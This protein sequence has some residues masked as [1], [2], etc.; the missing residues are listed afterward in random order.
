MASS[1]WIKIDKINNVYGHVSTN[2]PTIIGELCNLL[3]VYVK[4]YHHMPKYKVGLWD[5]KIRFMQQNGKFPLGLIKYIHK[6]IIQDG[7]DIIIDPA[8]LEKNE[9][10]DFIDVTTSWMTE[11]FIPYKHQLEGAMKALKY[12]RGI[13][14]HATSSGK[15]LTMSM[16]IMYSLIKKNNK[17]ILVLVPNLSLIEQLS[18]DFIKYG[19]PADWV[20]RYSGLQKDTEE[21]IIVSTWQSMCRQ[22]EMCQEFDMVIA[23]ECHSLKG[24]QVRSVSDN[25]INAFIRIGCTGT[26][27]DDKASY[28][29]IEGTLGPVLHVV[30]ARQ[31]IDEK[32]A[33][34]IIIK[35]PFIE[36]SSE[37][38][39]SLK[40]LPYDEEK[41]WLE[42]HAP[43]NNVIKT[44]V[45]KHSLVGH[46]SLVLVDHIEHAKQLYELIKTIDNVEVFV[47]TGKM[48]P[49]E[50]ERIRL[51][52]NTNKNIILIATYGTFAVGISINRLHAIVF[53]SA[54]KSK[55]KT[56]QSIGRGLRL[57]KEKFKLT[58]YDIGDSLEYSEKHLQNR[59]D[60]Y[61]KAEFDLEIF[62][63]K[64]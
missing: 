36:Y 41:G 23:D 8:I 49:E 1:T 42:T 4:G 54:G 17:K 28:M 44:I 45:K 63:V 31:L 46:N 62:E 22:P 53:A 24:T 25:A 38:K 5:G 60:I 51:Y 27:P 43:R 12:K 37:I 21:P 57:H 15:S 35:I 61:V 2:H 13:L 11:K 9:L 39:K 52:A 14:E 6:F 29:Q 32:Q 59:I 34:D 26:M 55:I 16:M 33:S 50:R 7:I 19:V 20:G 40:G 30:T 58:L 47:I 3:S 48:P 56:L 18:S 10:E 64:L